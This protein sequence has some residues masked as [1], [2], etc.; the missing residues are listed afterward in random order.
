MSVSEG[1]KITW[2]ITKIDKKK[3][4]LSLFYFD[5]PAFSK[6]DTS[7]WEIEKTQY[8]EDG[9]QWIIH[10]KS[11][12]FDEE[13]DDLSGVDQQ[14][15]YENGTDQSF[16]G[17]VM[18]LIPS[19]DVEKYL[20]DV[21]SQYAF[22]ESDGNEL[23][24]NYSDSEITYKFNKDGLLEKYTEEYDG[25]TILEYE[26]KEETAAIPFGFEFLIFIPMGVLISLYLIK[27][28]TVIKGEK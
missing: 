24:I 4:H 18:R 28:K 1:D 14:I 27:K 3:A 15:I 23:L 17:P 25:D 16:T 11:L 5:A 7:V 6:E 26:I 13:D 8:I 20:E 22:F 12:D 21:A 9:E 10:Y 19:D 2:E